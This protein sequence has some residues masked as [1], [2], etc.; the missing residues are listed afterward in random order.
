MGRPTDQII[1]RLV[2]AVVGGARP[3]LAIHRRRKSEI[4]LN[5]HVRILLLEDEPEA[6][7]ISERALYKLPA[8]D[9]RSALD[10]VQQRAPDLPVIM[11]SGALAAKSMGGSLSVASDGLGQ[12]ATFTLELPMGAR[13]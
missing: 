7:E 5:N 9:G 1:R 3:P 4:G 8:F 6:A 2:F 13:A 10:I 11:V 12:G